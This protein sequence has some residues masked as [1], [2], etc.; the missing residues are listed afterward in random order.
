[1]TAITRR[2]GVGGDWSTVAD[3]NLDSAPGD[4]DDV[5]IS[6]TGHPG[7]TVPVSSAAAAYS[8]TLMAVG[9]TLAVSSTLA[10]GTHS[11]HLR[12][13]WASPAPVSSRAARL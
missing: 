1:M 8:L 12:A 13:H 7:Y 6:A 9:A 5:T 3:W 4:L 11:Q 2:S 10:I